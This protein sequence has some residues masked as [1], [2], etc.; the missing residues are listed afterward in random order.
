MSDAVFRE[1]SATVVGI[2]EVRSVFEEAKALRSLTGRWVLG[3]FLWVLLSALNFF[4][5]FL[6][7]DDFVLG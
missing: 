1:L 5:T 4:L 6:K 2:N 3:D 7:E